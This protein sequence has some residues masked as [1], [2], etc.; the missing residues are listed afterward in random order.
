M[1]SDTALQ[2]TWRVKDRTPIPAVSGRRQSVNAFSAAQA[3]RA[4]R[5][6]GYTRRRNAAQFTGFLKNP[7]RPRRRPVFPVADGRPAHIAGVATAH[8]Q[9]L[10][11][12]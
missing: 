3:R 7:M 8:V 5:C 12:K 4:F 2:R 9:R 11:G 1:R 6:K 10:K